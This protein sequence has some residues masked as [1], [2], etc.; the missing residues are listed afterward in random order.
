LAKGKKK[1]EGPD[2]ARLTSIFTFRWLTRYGSYQETAQALNKPLY[3]IT[4]DINSLESFLGYSL[5]ARHMSK[6]TLTQNGHRFLRYANLV[7]EGF[8]KL[9]Q[10]HEDTDPLIIVTTNAVAQYILPQALNIFS[11]E[12][13]KCKVICL[14][15][16]AHYSYDPSRADI[17][18]GAP[19]N[20]R[21]DLSQFKITD[22]NY[23]FY[24]SKEYL[25]SNPIKQGIENLINHRMLVGKGDYEKIDSSI[26]ENNTIYYECTLFESIIKMAEFNMGIA[27]IPIEISQYMQHSLIRIFG[28]YEVQYPLSVAFSKTSHRK[29]PLTF[30]KNIIYD[31]INP[32]L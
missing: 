5:L 25:D 9:D 17:T 21:G 6:L 30:L 15:G 23:T 20:N 1:A 11:S 10:T 32:K 2:K 28:D 4:N 12:F 7:Y 27:L 16:G 18:I 19:Y 13:P 29:E 26:I 3:K 24:A 14:T 31:I 8:Q 22:Y